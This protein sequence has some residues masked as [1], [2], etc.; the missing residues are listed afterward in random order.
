M[1]F[2][3]CGVRPPYKFFHI[4]S[5]VNAYKKTAGNPQRDIAVQPIGLMTIYMTS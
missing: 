3:F 1:L 5:W 4:H 2:F